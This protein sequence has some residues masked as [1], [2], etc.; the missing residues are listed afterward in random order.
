MFDEGSFEPL[1][2]IANFSQI[3]PDI[4]LTF[5]VAFDVY[6]DYLNHGAF[7]QTVLNKPDPTDYY[8]KDNGYKVIPMYTGITM[9]NESM[10]LNDGKQNGKA[11]GIDN[12]VYPLPGMY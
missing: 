11:Y 3:E 6:S 10:A 4:R 8:I 7:N 9:G 12:S 5:N 1:V 2:A